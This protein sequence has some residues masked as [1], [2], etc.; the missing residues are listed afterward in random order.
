MTIAIATKGIICQSGTF[1]IISTDPFTVE[2][3][4]ECV[5]GPSADPLSFKKGNKVV[6]DFIIKTSGV[7]L[8]SAQLNA[9]TD[10]IFS[11]KKSRSDADIDSKIIKQLTTAGLSILPDNGDDSAN[12]RVELLS[13][14]TDIAG[15][16][17]FIAVQV[18]FSATNMQEGNILVDSQTVIC[19]SVLGDVIRG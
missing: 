16:K 17:Y 1:N 4:S 15:G 13:T 12:I 6:Y 10:I 7:R 19:V 18:N 2:L 8:T 14:D 5:N 9:A 11:I 3:K